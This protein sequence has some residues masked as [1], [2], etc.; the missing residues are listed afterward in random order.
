MNHAVGQAGT[1]NK[2]IHPS[3][4]RHNTRGPSVFQAQKIQTAKQNMGDERKRGVKKKDRIGKKQ[5]REE[6]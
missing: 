1:E 6:I 2:T 3:P 5:K 4:A